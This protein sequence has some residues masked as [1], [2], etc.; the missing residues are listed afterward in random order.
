VYHRRERRRTPAGEEVVAVG[1]PTE[2]SGAL[3]VLG[4]EGA[5]GTEG[6]K[7]FGLAGAVAAGVPFV[8][9]LVV[10]VEVWP[11]GPWPAANQVLFPNIG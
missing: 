4:V 5:E 6:A 9:P 7:G 2:K 10:T 11:E 8:V 3:V 1:V